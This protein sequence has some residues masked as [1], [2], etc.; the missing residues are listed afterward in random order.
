MSLLFF[1]GFEPY[2]TGTANQRQLV[3][4]G[5]FV[6]SVGGTVST[7]GRS[8]PRCCSGVG[9][10]GGIVTRSLASDAD[11]VFIGFAIRFNAS[12]LARTGDGVRVLNLAGDPVLRFYNDYNPVIMHIY[13][14]DQETPLWSSHNLDD[15]PWMYMEATLHFDGALG[16]MSVSME[17]ETILEEYGLDLGQG[18]SRL[19][20]QNKIGLYGTI[21]TFVDDVYVCDDLDT[22]D[23][24]NEPLGPVKV[25]GLK[26]SG[27]VSVQWTPDTGFAN[28]SRVTDRNTG[29]VDAEEPDLKD[30]YNVETVPDASVAEVLAV[31]MFTRAGLFNAGSGGVHNVV[32]DGAT[33]YVAPKTALSTTFR[34]SGTPMLTTRPSGGVWTRASAEA[35][36]VGVLSG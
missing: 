36:H 13:G 17:G 10:N 4:G 23:G 8:G 16:W 3:Q 24:M 27:D 7:G 20:L 29:H 22:G 32:K 11:T 19:V 12:T 1:E 18:L 9:V 26:P 30:L 34:T 14:P 5:N 6:S 35:L 33:E 31:Q 15:S 2:D 28:W 21:Y 25:Y